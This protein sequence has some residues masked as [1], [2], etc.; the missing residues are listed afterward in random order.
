MFTPLV[1]ETTASNII[2]KGISAEI[3]RYN[4]VGVGFSNYAKVKIGYNEFKLLRQ[5]S[6]IESQAFSFGAVPMTH[7]WTINND[8][9]KTAYLQSIVLTY[10]SDAEMYI[11]LKDNNDKILIIQRVFVGN[12]TISYEFST[13]VPLYTAILK[14]VQG[15]GAN[16]IATLTINGFLEEKS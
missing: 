1:K 14:L 15:A 5:S 8:T 13:P 9:T 7:T 11:Y 10:K 16:G 12:N 3:A 4:D 2:E 6:L